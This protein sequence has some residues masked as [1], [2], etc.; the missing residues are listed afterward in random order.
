MLLNIQQF[1]WNTYEVWITNQHSKQSPVIVITNNKVHAISQV[2]TQYL[3][4]L[5]RLSNNSFDSLQKT[6]KSYE[7]KFV[8]HIMSISSLHPDECTFIALHIYSLWCECI[9]VFRGEC[10]LLLMYNEH[11]YTF[12]CALCVGSIRTL[13]KVVVLMPMA[14]VCL[15]RPAASRNHHRRTSSATVSSSWAFMLTRYERRTL[16]QRL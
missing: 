5:A 3:S 1:I 14:A 7:Y 4:E 6:T 2:V 11:P 16:L 8:V 10:I 12:V 13:V 15:L 9:I